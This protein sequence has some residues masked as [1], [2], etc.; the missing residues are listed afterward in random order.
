MKSTMVTRENASMLY[1]QVID[2]NAT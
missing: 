2:P 1:A